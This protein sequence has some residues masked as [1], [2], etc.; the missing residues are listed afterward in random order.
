[1]APALSLHRRAVG[2]Q[3]TFA[4]LLAGLALVQGAGLRAMDK[5]DGKAAKAASSAPAAPAS[6]APTLPALEQVV[7]RACQNPLSL[8]AQEAYRA[9][10][11][12]FPISPDKSVF[13]KAGDL[14]KTWNMTVLQC[15]QEEVLM[16]TL[17]FRAQNGDPAVGKAWAEDLF[18]KVLK[19]TLELDWQMRQAGWAKD[20]KAETKAATSPAPH[21]AGDPG[22]ATAMD[23][24]ESTG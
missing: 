16:T 24:D 20:N 23:T 18:P 15:A 1:M 5:G 19:Q 17:L 6:P 14:L 22:G 10:R 13:R 21:A 3:R 4:W 8:N 2:A 9:Y 11:Q 12:Q 7:A